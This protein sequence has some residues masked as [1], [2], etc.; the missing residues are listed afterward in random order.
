M[1]KDIAEVIGDISR[2]GILINLQ[3]KHHVFISDS[4][5]VQLISIQLLF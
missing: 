4:G 2:I 5:H 3:G 1:E